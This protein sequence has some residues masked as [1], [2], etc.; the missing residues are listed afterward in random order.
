MPLH[1][2]APAWVTERDHLKKKEFLELHQLIN[3]YVQDIADCSNENKEISVY[4][5][6]AMFDIF[7]RSNLC[8]KKFISLQHGYKFSRKIKDDKRWRKE[9]KDNVS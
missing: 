8:Y 3:Q 5:L 7:K 9:I 6:L 1:H 2:C 4:Y